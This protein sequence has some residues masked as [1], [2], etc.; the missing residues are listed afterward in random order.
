MVSHNNKQTRDP[1]L[2]RNYGTNDSMLRYKHIAKYLFMDTFFATKKAGKSSRGHISCQLF[3]TDKG[4][5]YVV[6]MK[7]NDEVLQSVKKSSKDIGAPKAIIRDMAG[8]KTS[9]ALKM[10]FQEIGTMM[11]FLEEGTPW[12]N[13]YELY[14]G[15][16]KEAVQK[17]MK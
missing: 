15:F 6:P 1:K 8:K 13:K 17:D 10:F 11:W 2:S 4:F 5:V 3:V 16:I 7:S 9:Q 14:I 12:A